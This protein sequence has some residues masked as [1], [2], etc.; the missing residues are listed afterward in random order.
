MSVQFH[1]F[2]SSFMGGKLISFNFRAIKAVFY[3]NSCLFVM[4]I[5]ISMAFFDEPDAVI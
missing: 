4:S 2:C 3:A 1:C 5:W